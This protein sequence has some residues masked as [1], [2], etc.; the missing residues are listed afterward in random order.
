MS[1]SLICLNECWSTFSD[2]RKEDYLLRI[3]DLYRLEGWWSEPED[4]LEKLARIISGS[5]CFIAA[6]LEEAGVVLGMGRAISDKASDAYIQ[7][8]MVRPE[9]RRQAIA[10]SIIQSIITRLEQDGMTWIGLIAKPGTQPFYR[11]LGFSEMPGAS[12]MLRTNEI[13]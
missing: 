3:R 5:H 6:I 1:Y 8:V 4:T 2:R 13:M 11:S 12:P 9:A 7:D 10:S